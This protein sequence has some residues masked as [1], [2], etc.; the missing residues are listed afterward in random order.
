LHISRP[1]GIHFGTV[2]PE[3]KLAP[4]SITI[5]NDSLAVSDAVSIRKVISIPP[6]DEFAA[7]LVVKSGSNGTMPI[8]LSSSD[9]LDASIDVKLDPAQ[10]VD[11]LVHP[12]PGLNYGLQLQWVLVIVE[13]LEFPPLEPRQSPSSS[14]APSPKASRATKSSAVSLTSILKSSSTVLVFAR[15]IAMMV[16][17]SEVASFQF[18]VYSKPFVPDS[19]KGRS[20]SKTNIFT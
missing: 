10:S 5:R 6:L 3:S 9:S 13:R 16:S 12:K 4:Q 19:Y 17:S 2:T 18:D 20:L 15:P 7:E 8:S 11:I 14:L 1:N